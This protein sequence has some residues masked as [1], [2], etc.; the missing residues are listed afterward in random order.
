MESRP[1]ETEVPALTQENL[2]HIVKQA[3]NGMAY[4]ASQMIIHGDLATRNCIISSD[5]R[6]KVADL[7]IGHDVYR[8]DYFDNNEQLLPVR[9]MPPEI[10][11]SAEFT[12]HS[13]IWS[14]GVFCW[15]VFAFGRIPY[16]DI[17]DEEVLRFVPQGLRLELPEEGCP[18]SLY[19]LMK[20]CWNGRAESRPKFSRLVVA[21]IDLN[22]D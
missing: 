4:L 6:V 15:E 5:M 11:Q 18:M 22:L 2:L 20:E 3:A 13:D 9:W 10:L 17:T 21:I 16:E 7:G 1:D 8:E 12:L 14:F 19:C